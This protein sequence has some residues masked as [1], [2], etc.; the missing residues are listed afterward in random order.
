MAWIHGTIDGGAT[1]VHSDSDDIHIT[2]KIDG[3]SSATLTSTGGSIII[4]GKVD[5]GSKVTLNAAKAIRIGFA[6]NDDGEKKID[7]N[8]SVDAQAGEDISVGNKIDNNSNVNLVS[9]LGS[10]TI[11]GKIDHDSVVHLTAAGDIRIGEAGNDGAERKIDGNS[12][13]DAR[14]GGTIHLFNKIDGGSISGKHSVVKF[15]A[16]REITI[17]DKIDGGSIVYLAVSSGM[18]SSGS[19]PTINIGDKIGRGGTTVT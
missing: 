3:G 4:D 19:P 11:G 18:T 15:Q 13:V 2:G 7:G 6:G 8:S 1:V 14:A 12:N 5:G 17:D 16:C 10:I 9:N